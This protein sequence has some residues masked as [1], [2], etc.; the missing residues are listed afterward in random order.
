MTEPQYLKQAI[1]DRRERYV[2]QY[3]DYWEDKDIEQEVIAIINA[4]SRMAM[5][6]IDRCMPNEQLPD[7][8]DEVVI[9]MDEDEA[10]F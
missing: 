7:P 6:E 4:V 8:P 3:T 10:V 1:E 9:K 2:E 5:L